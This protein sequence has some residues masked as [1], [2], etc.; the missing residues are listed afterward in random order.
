M[1]TTELKYSIHEL[2]ESINDNKA[3]KIIHTILSK[4]SNSKD[5]LTVLSAAE[6]KAV[7]EALK[8]VKAGK[9]HSHEKV[10]ADMKKKYPTLIK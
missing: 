3:L 10:M 9:V 7:D 4:L 8:S 6:K 2:V 5:T 1:S